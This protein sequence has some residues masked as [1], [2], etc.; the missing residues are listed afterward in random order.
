MSY[1]SKLGW[2][3][4]S[5]NLPTRH[6]D[7][8]GHSTEN[9]MLQK[10]PANEI[11]SQVRNNPDGSVTLLRTRNGFP[12]FTTTAVRII[13]TTVLRGFV[14]RLY[15]AIT[16]WLFDERD[17]SVA[18]KEYTP[19]GH[20]YAVAPFKTA[21]GTISD[22]FNDVWYLRGGKLYINKAL[23]EP[24]GSMAALPLT[25]RA[26]PHV[27]KHSDFDPYG[28]DAENAGAVK[29][30][31]AVQPDQVMAGVQSGTALTDVLPPVSPRDEFRAL[32]CGPQV[33]GDTAR[34]GQLYYTGDTFNDINGG[35]VFSWMQTSMLLT[36]SYLSS[37]TGSYGVALPTATPQYLGTSESTSTEAV[38]LPEVACAYMTTGSF[39]GTDGQR[40]QNVSHRPS[41]VIK[42]PMNGEITRERSNRNWSA[43]YSST[44][45]LLGLPISV[46]VEL[47]LRYADVNE[48]KSMERTTF[49]LPGSGENFAGQY[50]AYEN[51]PTPDFPTEPYGYTQWIHLGSAE[52]MVEYGE[53]IEN[54]LFEIVCDGNALVSGEISWE[55]EEGD[56]RVLTPIDL[57]TQHLGD[58]DDYVL[59]GCKISNS[60]VTGTPE[61]AAAYALVLDWASIIRD[62]QGVVIL[63]SWHDADIYNSSVEARPNKD[64]RTVS[65]TTKDFLLYDKEEGVY[66]SVEGSFSGQQSYGNNGSASL[67]VILRVESPAGVHTQTLGEIS[68]SAV[69]LFP[70]ERLDAQVDYLPIPTLRVMFVPKYRHQGNFPGVAYTT[71][72]EVD[73]GC[74]STF[75]ANFVLALTTYEGAFGSPEPDDGVV[76]FT[77]CNLMEMIYAYVFSDQYGRNDYEP[78]PVNRSINYENLMN[79]LFSTPIRV[80]VRNDESVDW[81]DTFGG[82]FATQQKTEIYRT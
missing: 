54:G 73:A 71:A 9:R 19:V 69:V 18:N 51:S 6:G 44:D 65:W 31:F 27:L 82:G 60:L 13:G 29:R 2:P 76:R 23:F 57:L 25:T 55:F 46:L 5:P 53:W 42:R 26:I 62:I 75:L 14:A 22:R 56:Q 39:A 32:V 63:P 47:T 70:L 67:T 66:I 45:T 34:L 35:W 24:L 52:G 1:K 48:W 77:P 64:T 8:Q 79:G 58:P 11:R 20:G 28:G 50:E 4:F 38:L 80:H 78:Y 17:L 16:G 81:L 41:S 61:A 37:V 30:V 74:P 59:T 40:F 72:G 7:A 43:A 12:E 33:D 3:D 21:L 49:S 68:F 36:S 10:T 15:G